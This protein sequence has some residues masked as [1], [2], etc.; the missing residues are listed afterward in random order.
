MNT[1]D[2]EVFVGA[3]SSGSISEAG[4]RLGLMPMAATRRLSALE[5]TLGVRLLHRTT[6]SLSLTPEGE[7]FL[8]YAQAIIENEHQG[9]A[10]VRADTLGA[11]GLLRVS[12]PIVFGVKIVTPL[13]SAILAA[14]PE[15][16]IALDMN[17][18]LPDL[19]AT[20]TDLAI[21]IARLKDS[22]L[23]AQKLADNPRTLVASPGYLERRGMPRSIDDLAHHDCLP[24]TGV[25]HWTFVAS[26]SETHVR[27]GSRF[28]S[29]SI[30]GCQSA[31]VAGA[32]I[33]LLSEWAIADDVLE[34]RL[35]RVVLD[36]ATPEEIG[37][38]AV[39]P[40]TRNVLPK[41]RVF[42]SALRLA[43]QAE[44]NAR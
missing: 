37:I 7:T 9:R 2:I 18:R 21:R 23:I 43:L 30:A 4:R 32:G 39:Y 38:W 27:I 17:D 15:L 5:A 31:C 35:Q 34:G 16:Q 24:M 3:V 44:T 11:A 41:V 33:T 13:V 28:S 36:D 42:V 10:Q 8:P 1:D 40:T 29:S 22:S 25:T 26:G 19:T 20:G 12:V 6:R 14:N